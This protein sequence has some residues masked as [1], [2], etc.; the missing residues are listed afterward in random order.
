MASSQSTTTL[1]HAPGKLKRNQHSQDDVGYKAEMTDG[2]AGFLP[3]KRQRSSPP[4]AAGAMR[5]SDPALATI[6][7][8]WQRSTSSQTQKSGPGRLLPRAPSQSK[9]RPDAVE[10]AVAQ[11]L[12]DL[13]SAV[14]RQVMNPPVPHTHAA[15]R[16]APTTT[17]SVA[18][19]TQQRDRETSTDVLLSSGISSVRLDSDPRPKSHRTSGVSTPHDRSHRRFDAY[20]HFQRRQ[21]QMS[22]DDS[23]SSIDD[24]SDASVKSRRKRSN[25][26]PADT[27]TSR[28]RLSDLSELS[29]SPTVASTSS[30]VAAKKRCSHHRNVVRTEVPPVTIPSYVDPNQQLQPLSSRAT[31]SRSKLFFTSTY[32]V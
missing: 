31:S 12:E 29:L 24:A 25:T 28:R 10:E 17:M 20:R 27:S 7:R 23:D 14:E 16:K 18:P 26:D 13:V 15:K 4:P 2:H 1:P 32:K 8:V 22:V 3:G 30:P 9:S 6:M 5:R 21:R 19:S 11:A